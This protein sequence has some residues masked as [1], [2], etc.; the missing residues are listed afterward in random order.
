MGERRGFPWALIAA[1]FGA[2]LLAAQTSSPARRPTPRAAVSPAPRAT[3]TPQPVPREASW[4]EVERLVSE[5]KFEEASREIDRLLAA[6]KAS[7]DDRELALALVRSTQLR[8]ALHGYETAVRNLREEPWP[9]ALLWRAGV[10]LYYAQALE[11]YAQAYSWEVNQREKVESTAPVD[12]KAWTREQIYDEAER[13]YLELWK[14]REALGR[15]PIS[16]LSDFVVAN[17]YPKEIRGTV[18]DALAYFFVELLSNSSGWTAAEA[19]EVYRLGAA[20]LLDAEAPFSPGVEDAAGHPL[21]RAVAALGDLEAWHAARGEREAALEAYLERVRRIHAAF[22]AEEDRAAIRAQ[23]TA[24]LARDRRLPWS[25]VGTA[26]LAELTEQESAPD[27]LIRARKIALDGAEAHPNTIGGRRCASIAARIAHPEHSLQAMSSDGAKRRS[28]EVQHRNLATLYFRAWRIDLDARLISAKDYNLLPDYNEW[29]EMLGKPPAARWSEKLPPTPDYRVHRTFV[30]P[31]LVEPGLYMVAAADR[32][33]FAEGRTGISSLNFLRTDLV[34][35]ARPEGG[36]VET[37]VLEGDSGDAASGADV[38]LWIYDWQK[39]HRR[40][41]TK[42]VDAGGTARFSWKEGREN[43]P[44]FFLARRG[45]HRALDSSYQNF[46]PERETEQSATLVFTDRAIYRPLQKLYWKTL[47]YHGRPSEGR[48]AISPGASLTVSLID[49]NNERLADKTVTTNAYGSASGEFEI[50]AGR[51]LGAWRLQT[52]IPGSAAIRVEEYKRPTFEAMWKDPE[53]PLRLN[54]PA[55]LAGNAR[56]YF[57]LPVTNG[58]VVWRVSRTPQFPWW[59]DWGWWWGPRPTQPQVVAQGVSPLSADGTFT[60]AFTPEADERL[61]AAS[62]EIT[63]LY[64]A[65]ADV[66]DEG[67]ET[68]SASRAF[69]LGFVSIEARVH[70]ENA[71]LRQ[72]EKGAMSAMRTSLDGV[73]RAGAARWRLTELVPAA[74]AFLPSQLPRPVAPALQP[75]ATPGDRMRA[76]WDTSVTLEET[77][78]NWKDGKE[79]AQG[80]LAHDAQGRA[81]WDLPPLAP[82][83]YRLRYETKDEFGV[84]FEVSRDLLCSGRLEADAPAPLAVVLL[85]EQTLVPVGGTARFLAFSAL[86]DQRMAFEIYKD[87]RLVE[88]RTLRSGKDPAMIEIPITENARGGFGVKLVGIRDHQLLHAVTSIFVPWDDRELEVS[89]ATFRDRLRPGTD[90]TW[91]VTVK[92]KKGNSPERAAELLAW[93]YDRSLDAFA[94]FSPPDPMSLWPN[95]SIVGWMR[96]SLGMV[97]SQWIASGPGHGTDYPLLQGDL[98]KLESGYGIGGPGRRYRQIGAVAAPASE[99]DEMAADRAQLQAMPAKSRA[100]V[101]NKPVAKEGKDEG[102]SNVAGVA[103][104]PE[105]A[106]QMRSEFSETAFWKP[107]LITGED[108]SASIEFH[109]PDSVTSWKVWVQAVTKDLHSGRV[110]KESAS[111]KELMVRPYVPRFLR[112]GDKAELKVVVNNAAE[113]DL[114]GTVSLEILNPADNA[115]VLSSWGIA[116][117]AATK[118]FQVAK[119]GGTNLTFPI[120]VPRGTGT[121]AFRV[122]AKSGDLSDG[123]LRP[124]PVLPSRMV[125]AQSRF[126]ALKEGDRRTLIFEDLAR[127]GDP[128]R[129]DEQIVVTVDAQLFYGMLSALPYLV[130]YPYECTEQTL[131]R[132]VSTGILSSLYGQYPSVAKMAEELSKR[133]TRLE[134]FDAADPNRRM[135]LEETPWLEEAR[136]GPKPAGEL[137]KVLDPRIAKAQRE[138]SLAKLRKAQTAIGGF[139]WWPGGPPSPYMTIY[140]LHGMANA[141]EFSVPVPK[142]MTLRA[143]NYVGG[144][145]RSEMERCMAH[146]GTCEFVTFVNYT[147]SSFPDASWYEGSFTDADR[148]R[149]LDYSFAHWKG[150]SPYLK[151]MLAMTLKR[152]GRGQDA[153]LVW[154]S[155]MDSSKTDKDTGTSWAP[156][157]R[158]W[159]WYNDT[160]ETHAYALRTLTELTPK[161]PRREGLVQWLF[162]NKKMN[163]WK[164]TRATS[165]VL[166]SLAHYLKSESALAV[167]EAVRVTVGPVSAAFE[168]DPER[169]TGKKNQIVVPGDKIDPKTSSTIVAEKS[170]KGLAFVSAT[171]H[172]STE[173]LPREDRGDFFHVSR[174]YFRREPTAGGFTLKPLADGTPIAP[175]DQIEVQISLRSKHEAEYVHLRDPR[176]A[177]LEPEN[178][179]SG[180]KWNLGIVWYEET[181]DSGTNFFF[182]KLPVG[183]Y[184]FKYR[185]RANMAGTFRV[186]P[187]TVQSMYA[188]E[189]TAYSAGN[190]MTI[191]PAKASER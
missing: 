117:A 12:L 34:L 153:T 31:P 128:T 177:G 158:S 151:G 175:G 63:Y 112:E 144:E 38:E 8:M 25:A 189:F 148:K 79:V 141:L 101:G 93:M 58:S 122:V 69:R 62:R 176:A 74:Q 160:I 171:W 108:G 142:D 30:T 48:M 187:A 115:S 77:L 138:E 1:V 46:S 9:K 102:R 100:D 73:A 145:L 124:V 179:L 182:E 84:P 53:S 155:V 165:E 94:P 75:Y 59:W 123:E 131:N 19:N 113:K 149:Y 35:M 65:V 104:E 98:L 70:P 186:A 181:R 39:G 16:A 134:T 90:E 114:S 85:A 68:R 105:A 20:G 190:V 147:L 50:P 118:P 42:R 97:S 6:A 47:S 127:G 137:L 143:W 43:K 10:S 95:R 67:G 40:V 36:S 162:L 86:P 88:R 4:K 89:F 154:D 83:A 87:G 28:F 119:G 140:I 133:D 125:L 3:A 106:V 157:D 44:Y 33:D 14:E 163:H 11:A 37:R 107:H 78:R 64:E 103:G 156:E 135:A 96:S 22:S 111:I 45:E 110:V 76:R 91:K 130:D 159:L 92:A 178:V 71:F 24:R 82:G 121:V 7:G 2:G 116:A 150:H 126:A 54:R 49:A 185:L 13:V 51:A 152:A 161:D 169:Y 109:V 168:F 191:V 60:I 27:A 173:K 80:E 5:Q 41:E 146:G 17:N 18:R 29:R 132:F 61:A 81:R 164:S 120:T 170:G 32:E 180:H 55:K 166:Y 183:E 57:G 129:I 66:T 184:T 139:P 167:R 26:L 172:F 136:G 21:A 99:M 52:S 56:Y 23:L 15:E 72:G 188:P 174:R